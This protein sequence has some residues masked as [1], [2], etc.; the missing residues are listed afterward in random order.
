MSIVIRRLPMHYIQVVQQLDAEIFSADEPAID[1]RG[2]WWVAWDTSHSPYK[3]VAFAGCRR[4]SDDSYGFFQRAG[5]LPAY[6]GQGIHG[7]LID[8]RLRWAKRTHLD[9]VITYTVLDNTASANNLI[10]K[11]F[12]LF[13]PLNAWAG[14]DILYFAIDFV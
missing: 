11:G 6:R 1:L 14:E 10:D 5:V 7:R 3:P 12:R 13:D 2:A 4:L 8:A 9:G